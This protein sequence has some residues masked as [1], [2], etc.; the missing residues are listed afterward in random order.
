MAGKMVFDQPGDPNAQVV[1]QGTITTIGEAGLVA[2]AAPQVVNSGSITAHLGHVVLAGAKT[3]TLDLYGDG[4]LSLDVSNE[5]TQTPVG[6][7]G[8]AVTA[9]V[10]NT[11]AVDVDGGT[12]QLTARAADGIVQSLVH[13]GGTILADSVG[14]QTGTVVLGGL[15]GSIRVTGQLSALGKA[16]GTTGG[17]IQ[18]DGS[19]KV[20]VASPTLINASGQAGGGVVAIGTTLARAQGGPGTAST[21]TAANTTIAA[22]ATIAANATANGDGGRVTVLSTG[23]PAWRAASPPKADRKVAMAGSSRC[24]AALCL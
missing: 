21:L 23:R 12:A 9:L 13:A 19:G 4:L 24:R 17:E 5:V 22:E 7:N 6:A 20:A 15:G 1:N 3:A 16:P 10:T 18:V 8:K 2:L 11:G 14:S